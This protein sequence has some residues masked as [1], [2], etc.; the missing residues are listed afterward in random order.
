MK[1][2]FSIILALC[3]IC[4]LFAHNATYGDAFKWVRIGKLWVKVLDNG[5]QSQSNGNNMASYWFAPTYTNFFR[6]ASTRWAS[7][8]W[9]DETGTVW[10][11]KLSGGGHDVSDESQNM[12][13][14]PDAEEITIHRYFRYKPPT[15]VLDGHTINDPFPQAGDEVA[16]TKIIG[17]ADVMIESNIRV[18]MGIDI[19][20]RVF[21]WSQKNHDDYAIWEFKMTNTGNVDRDATVELPNQTLTG[22]YFSREMQFFVNSGRREWSSWEAGKPGDSLRIMYNYP[23]RDA[24]DAYDRFG[25][26]NTANGYLRGPQYGG[27]AML[28]VQKS[29]TDPTDDP[30]KPGTYYIRGPD[31]LMFS[32]GDEERPPSEYPIVY[33]VYQNGYNAY[34]PQPRV[35]PMMQGTYPGLHI[36]LPFDQRGKQW[37][38]DYADWWFWHA[39]VGNASGPYTLGPGQSITVAWA[40]V[41]GS[42]SQAKAWEIARGWKSQTLQPPPG[43]VFGTSVNNRI[44]NLPPQYK[45][46]P[47]LYK[48]DSY[49]NEINNWAKDCWVATGKDSLFRNALNAKW[50]YQNI[51]NVPTGPPP[52]SI[53]VESRPDNVLITW[54]NESESASDLAGYNIYRAI[55]TVDSVI[56]RCI[57]TVG[58]DIH[59][60]EDRTAQRGIGYAYAVTAFDDGTS[61]LADYNGKKEVLESS[62]F[63][64][65]TAQ[66]STGRMAVLTRPP[67]TISDVRVVPNPFSLR[68]ID[69]QFTGQQDK[70]MFLNLPPIC[71]IKIYSES[72]DLVKTLEHTNMSGDESWGNLTEEFSVTKTGQVIVSGIYIALIET[73]DGKKNIVKFAVVR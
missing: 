19:R 41:G 65:Q 12:F 35:T 47:A 66:T 42:I 54:G 9:K 6:G 10:P 23:N 17:T 73:P 48:A 37:I 3:L 64:T 15:I 62:M 28:Y 39:V 57:K 4:F 59:S 67:K 31:D 30:T 63:L 69:M 21:F 7:L 61:N 16:P 8:N 32:C 71:T 13:A 43:M 70:I 34:I 26:L 18:W 14:L 24:A 45:L 1:K 58:K 33:A 55:P 60:Y 27:E 46:Y 25:N 56:Y 52:P 2:N 51:N 68:A 72:G 22:L 49:S 36:D 20:Q 50:A 29:A 38:Q 53:E 11:I 40:A 5:H 44:D